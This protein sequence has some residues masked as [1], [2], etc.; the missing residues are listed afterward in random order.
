MPRRN[1]H[2]DNWEFGG[3]RPRE[4]RVTPE[5][6]PR[7]RRAA[8]TV[9][10]TALFFSGAALTA[11]A[12]DKFSH[13]S[14]DDPP[15]EQTAT[16]A[17]PPAEAPAS[18]PVPAQAEAPAAAPAPEPAPEPG[19]DPASVPAPAEDPAAAPAEDPAAAPAEDPAAAPAEDPAAAAPEEAAAESAPT[20]EASAD[21]AA[22]PMTDAPAAPA[23]R[24]AKARTT[25]RARARAAKIVLLPAVKPAPKPELEGP[26]AGATV[27][28]NSPSVDP[29]PPAKRVS[30]TFA[31]RL[32]A[33]AKA[34]GLDWAFVL[35]V[36]RAKGLTGKTP[37]D[38][39]TLSKLADRLATAH[40][41]RGGWAAALAYGGSSEFADR[42]TALARYDRAVGLHALVHGLAADK[43]RLAAKLLSDPQVS[44]YD[45]GRQDIVRGRVDV[46]VLAVI[47]YLHEAYGAVTV[48]CLISGHRLYARPGVVSAHIYGRAVD[49]AALGGQAVLG[50]SAPGG[51]TEHAVRDLLLLPTEVMP[52]QVIS[53]LGLGGPS[54]PLANH[55]DHIH[56]GF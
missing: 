42:A 44:I 17:A 53:L 52:Q 39:S 4:E 13:V 24:P 20:D 15:A 41:G 32:Q 1:S 28:L 18:A 8:T 35:G 37:V 49:I 34:Q 23:G 10:F 40:E 33:T 9:A 47:A 11:V 54:F 25:A 22:A 6:K 56:I 38:A 29:T 31:R 30:A 19:T 51:M 48:S 14:S 2:S 27:W 21:P 16:E 12:G 5:P 55:A 46:R 3:A 26:P 36:L 43:T 45:G 50:N 7:L